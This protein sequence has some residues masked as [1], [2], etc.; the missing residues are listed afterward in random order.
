MTDEPKLLT[1]EEL[2]LLQRAATEK[3]LRPEYEGEK[4]RYREVVITPSMALRLVAEVRRLR[5]LVRDAAPLIWD[6]NDEEAPST[7]ELRAMAGPWEEIARAAGI[8]RADP[9]DWER[10]FKADGDRG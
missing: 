8:T 10:H 3:K 9:P 2:E 1:E 7:P 4:E 6:V 5:Q